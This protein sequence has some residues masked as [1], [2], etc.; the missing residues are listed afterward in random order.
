MERPVSHFPAGWFN[1]L[2]TLELILLAFTSSFYL[3]AF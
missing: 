1:A 3:T 2:S